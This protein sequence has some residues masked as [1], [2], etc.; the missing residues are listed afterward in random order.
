MGNSANHPARDDQR[1]QPCGVVI[2]GATGDLAQR[3]LLPSLFRL[4]ARGLLP[5]Q[6]YVLGVGREAGR[7]A[8][9]AFRERVR[10]AA[11]DAGADEGAAKTLLDACAYMGGAL[12][13]AALYRDIAGKVAAMDEAHGTGGR[14]LYYLALPP[15]LHAT[16]VEGLGGAK[17]TREDWDATTWNRVVVEKP[18]GRDLES[19]RDL[20]RRLQSVL[21]ERQIYRIDHSSIIEVRSAASP[22]KP[23]SGCCS[24]ACSAT[25]RCSCAPTACKRAGR[26]SPTCSIPGRTER[27]ARAA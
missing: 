21:R 22:R 20:D 26:S 19:A 11:A 16:V 10:E 9:K 12:D 24:T 13:D 2:F 3:K 14:H 27:S 18:F 8:E 15:D 23:T 4:A 5:E 25:R 1:P 17:L 6:Y 7:A